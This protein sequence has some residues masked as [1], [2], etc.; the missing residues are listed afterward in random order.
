MILK[1]VDIPTVY[2][3]CEEFSENEM[4]NCFNNKVSTFNER[5]FNLTISKGLHF[6]E[7]KQVEA[8]FII[9]ENGNVTGKKVRSVSLRRFDRN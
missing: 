7:P 8:F 6:S 2:Y 3:G 5:E 9:S 4:K 1:D